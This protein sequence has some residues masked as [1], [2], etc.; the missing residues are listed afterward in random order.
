MCPSTVYLAD[1]RP[2]SRTTLAYESITHTSTINS[3]HATYG[4][5]YHAS[6]CAYRLLSFSI[7]QLGSYI[8]LSHCLFPDDALKPPYPCLRR[9]R[10]DTSL[11]QPPAII[12]PLLPSTTRDPFLFVYDRWQD[13]APRRARKARA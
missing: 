4:E 8:A 9:I 13:Q 11:S 3:T 2:H 1:T 10:G 7:C 5:A 12:F 6:T